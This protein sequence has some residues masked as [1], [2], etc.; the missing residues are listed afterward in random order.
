MDFSSRC[1]KDKILRELV[2][3]GFTLP[4]VLLVGGGG[5]FTFHER[6]DDSNLSEIHVKKN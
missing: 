1:K 5:G 6:I 2:W 3:L 4:H